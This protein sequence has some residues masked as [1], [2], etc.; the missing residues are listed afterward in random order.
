MLQ[1]IGIMMGAYI[2]TR[3][4]EIIN[5]HPKS[6]P[7]IVFAVITMIVTGF[8]VLGLLSAKA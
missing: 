6:S 5:V 3:M 7:V 2:F 8:C 4:V 1:L